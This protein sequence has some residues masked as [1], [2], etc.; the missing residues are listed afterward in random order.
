[1]SSSIPHPDSGSFS[2]NCAVLTV[3]DTRTEST[4]KSGDLIKQML[5]ANGHHLGNYVIIKDEP[6][7]ITQALNQC[8]GDAKIQAVIVNG[9]T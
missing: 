2:V 1:M 3:S 6:D 5:R 9:G 7:L 4:D 8:C